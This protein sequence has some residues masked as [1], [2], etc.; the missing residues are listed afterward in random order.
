VKKLNG[1]IGRAL[2][3]PEFAGQISA[4]GIDPIFCFGASVGRAMRRALS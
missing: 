2:K 4:I 3:D 1:E